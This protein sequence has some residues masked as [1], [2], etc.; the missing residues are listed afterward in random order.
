MVVRTTILDL[1]RRRTLHHHRPVDHRRSQNKMSISIYA[2][3]N[4]SG[5]EEIVLSFAKG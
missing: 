4:E 3:T 5:D 1:D 2:Y